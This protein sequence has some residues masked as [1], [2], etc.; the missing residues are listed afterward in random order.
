[1][2]EFIHYKYKPKYLEYIDYNYKLKKYLNNLTKYE[3]NNIILYGANGTCKKTFINTYLNKC[4][5]NDNSIY[6]TTTYDYILS[7]NYK[8]HYKSSNKH[9]QVHLLDNYKNNILIVHELLNYL[10][11]SQSIM[12]NYTIIILHNIHKLHNNTN[13][14][15]NIMEKYYNVKFLCS[16]LRRHSDLEVAIQLR[17]EQLSEFELLKIAFIINKKEKLYLSEDKLIN[18]VKNS[19][20]NINNLL[21][22]L[23]SIINKTDDILDLLNNIIKILEKKNIKDYPKIKQLLNK[24]II[25]NSYNIYFI[26]NYIYDKIIH[27]IKNKHEFISYISTLNET[28]NNI[29]K[30]IITLDTYIFYIYKMMK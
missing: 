19:K 9:Y 1:M 7:N 4:F 22:S 3:I 16:S 27:F 5:N 17:T 14:L 6:N 11:K 18:I 20:N 24:I 29:V 13:L 23:Q 12:N 21:N 26:I 15:K 2:C 25:F 30:N 10:I 8:I 28:N